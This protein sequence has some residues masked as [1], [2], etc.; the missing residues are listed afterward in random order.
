[1]SDKPPLRPYLPLNIPNY[2]TFFRPV[3]APGTDPLDP[4]YVCVRFNEE[5]LPYVLGALARL[6][7]EDA[8]RG[9]QTAQAEAIGHARN[10]IAIFAA[11]TKSGCF[12]GVDDMRLRQK[13]GEPCVLQASY[14]G[15]D[16]W[17]DVFDYA[18]C[19]EEVNKPL[20]DLTYIEQYNN[21]QKTMY[22]IR[23]VYN[24]TPGSI[25][26]ESVDGS[27]TD[28]ANLNLAVCLAVRVLVD[29]ACESGIQAK[30]REDQQ[31]DTVINVTASGLAIAGLVLATFVFPPAGLAAASTSATYILFGLGIASASLPI[32][33]LLTQA[34]ISL[35]SNEDA[36]KEVICCMNTALSGSQ[37]TEAA[38][39]ASLDACGTLSSD[40]EELRGI[41][42]EI[43]Q[44]TDVYLQYLLAMDSAYASSQTG[45]PEIP[46]CPC[47]V[48][49]ITRLNGDGNADLVVQSYEGRGT[50]TPCEGT[51]DAGEDR[52]T[53]C[54]NGIADI[55][56]SS[57]RV[58]MTFSTETTI[59]RL[60]IAG[61]TQSH[62]SG[63]DNGMLWFEAFD[64]SGASVLLDFLD[65]VAQT[66]EWQG[67][68]TNVLYIEFTAR[69]YSASGQVPARIE[70]IEVNGFG[71][72][73]LT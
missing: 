1:M 24:G 19:F 61:Y 66:H 25:A 12:E 18:A 51:Y 57:V 62:R 10:L 54:Y 2:D 22:D 11:A 42:R 48:W 35:F 67:E 13:P 31:D 55:A 16:S 23:N 73:P 29:G 60:Y 64:S 26:T 46:P 69:S 52:Y 41:V 49:S 5:W 27:A 36:K 15:G 8:W 59:S 40:G 53:E 6:E 33:S 7:F 4:D 38:F 63:E 56:T 45:G 30:Q 50:G 43:I 65:G 3:D 34:D 32:A 47:D 68:V 37:P 44:D 58:R 20:R 17:S 71:T 28:P 14:D 72:N 39:K 9:D 21:Y 70:R